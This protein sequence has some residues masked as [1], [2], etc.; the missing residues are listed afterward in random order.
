[1]RAYARVIQRENDVPAKNIHAGLYYLEGAE[2]V[3]ARFTDKSLM[4]AEESLLYTYKQIENTPEDK[5]WGNVG[6]HCRRCD[7][8]NRC[9]FHRLT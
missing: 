8:V 9:P 5:A 7:Y 3:G 4:K 6:R 2:L 1:L